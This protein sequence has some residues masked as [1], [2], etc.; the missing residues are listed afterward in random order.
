MSGTWIKFFPTDW[1]HGTR[2]LTPVERGVYITLVA[3]MYD[4][5]GP[6]PLNRKRLARECN[7]TP[8]L[9]DD[10][11]ETLV[12]MGKV[13]IHDNA[14]FNEKTEK[15][16]GDMLARAEN[17]RKAGRARQGKT[18]TIQEE[19]SAP[20]DQ[21]LTER[22]ADDEQPLSARSA[23]QDT[24]SK[25]RKKKAS[26]LAQSGSVEGEG[27]DEARSPA[28]ILEADLRHA[29]G[30]H[31]DAPRLSHVKPIEDLIAQGLSLTDDVIPTIR[32]LAANV[33]SRTSWAYFVGPLE[34]LLRRRKLAQ[35][36]SPSPLVTGH[37]EAVTAPA[38]RV[39]VWKGTPQWEAWK[40]TRKDGRDWPTTEQLHPA[41]GR[42]PG[43]YFETEWP[44]GYGDVAA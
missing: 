15:I 11:L 43:W 3:M 17:A 40:A 28:E 5:Q 18:Q 19:V 7:C 39:W 35:A 1:L 4:E 13:S 20:A 37:P 8:K 10:T 2:S 41:G 29:A 33:E 38:R 42:R 30:W 31:H 6:I 23:I 34:D 32:Q 27:E 24:R 21:P 44:P 26:K 22:L 14:I 12:E 25:I 16:L 36:P 9:F